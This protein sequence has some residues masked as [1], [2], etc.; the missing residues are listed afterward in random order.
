MPQANLPVVNGI[1]HN[2]NASTTF[3]NGATISTTANPFLPGVTAGVA[4]VPPISSSLMMSV[5]SMMSEK[6]KAGGL[7]N[8]VSTVSK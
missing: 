3:T 2:G 8:K 5:M 7:M 6:L 1:H 4:G